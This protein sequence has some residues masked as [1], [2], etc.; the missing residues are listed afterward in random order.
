MMHVVPC[1]DVREQL[2]A[3]LD[4][5]LPLDDQVS[6]QSH[7]Q[8]CVACRLEANDL[9]EIGAALRTASVSMASSFPGERGGLTNAILER[10]RVERQLSFGTQVKLLFED[11][12]LVWA[13]LGATLATVICVCASAGVLHAASRERPD[14]LAGI[15]DYLANP[16][17]NANPVRL[18]DFMDVPRAESDTAMP[19]TSEDAEVALAA[20]VTRE[21]RIQNLEVLV[22][23]QARKYQVRPEVVLAMLQAAGR[24]RFEPA[25]SGGEP[26]AVS[27]VWLL[28]TTTVKGVPDY[29]RYLLRPPRWE[30]ATLLGPAV[31]PKPRP[32][33]APA[34]KTPTGDCGGVAAG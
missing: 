19:V 28:S 10:V 23:E 31:P 33:V 21:G 11:M 6:V 27:M 4:G 8:E 32:V 22:Q 7:L 13:G 24:A 5:E 1:V 30:K 15:I 25:K 12:H 9:R 29:D 34:P 16:G 3:F 26:V 17:S 18:G 14:S 2:A 20:V